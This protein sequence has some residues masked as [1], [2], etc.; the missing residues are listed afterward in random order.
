MLNA[1]SNIGQLT[2]LVK[3]QLKQIQRRAAVIDGYLASNLGLLSS[4]LTFLYRWR[5]CVSGT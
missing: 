1:P 4:N 5:N 3:S 2:A